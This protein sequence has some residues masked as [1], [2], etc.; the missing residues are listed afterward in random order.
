MPISIDGSLVVGFMWDPYAIRQGR[1]LGE[2]YMAPDLAVSNTYS[3][4]SESAISSSMAHSGHS[5]MVCAA[6][7]HPQ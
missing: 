5:G 3:R 1:E 2:V 6:R 7:M 4:C